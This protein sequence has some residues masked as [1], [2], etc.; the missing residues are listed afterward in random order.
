M[1][2]TYGQSYPWSVFVISFLKTK[3][4]LPAHLLVTICTPLLHTCES[5]PTNCE[6]LATTRNRR[7]N[8]ILL[9]TTRKTGSTGPY[10]EILVKC[11][12]IREE[13]TRSRQESAFSSVSCD[14]VRRKVF[15]SWLQNIFPAVQVLGL[16]A[17][18][19][20]RWDRESRAAPA[21]SRC[22]AAPVAVRACKAERGRAQAGN[23]RLHS[24]YILVVVV[25]KLKTLREWNKKLDRDWIKIG[26]KTAFLLVISED[27]QHSI[28]PQAM[29]NTRACQFFTLS[30]VQT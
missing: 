25:A 27:T 14:L 19:L 9:N 10:P 2:V 20:P 7:T 28:M 15:F 12:G 5:T 24:S 8:S 22:H 16:P 21:L 6:R 1:Y 29:H 13:F 3:S 17:R 18:R 30:T 26:I 11:P 23:R 4:H